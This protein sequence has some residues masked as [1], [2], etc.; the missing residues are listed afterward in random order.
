MIFDF[1]NRCSSSKAI[2]F[3]F[4]PIHIYSLDVKSSQRVLSISVITPCFKNLEPLIGLSW[5]SIHAC[6]RLGF[7]FT[8]ILTIE[9]CSLYILFMHII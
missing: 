4:M 5:L 1:V 3:L 8:F 6:T 9:Y 2:G 7:S